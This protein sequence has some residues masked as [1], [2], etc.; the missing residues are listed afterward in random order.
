MIIGW[1][2]FGFVILI[3]IGFS[4][5]SSSRVILL[6]WTLWVAL[7]GNGLKEYCNIMTGQRYRLCWAS[8]F[9]SLISCKAEM[10]T[11]IQTL[12]KTEGA[13]KNS[14]LEPLAVL[15]IQDTGR[16][17]TKYKN[18]TQKL[19]KMSNMDPTKKRVSAKGKQFLPLLRNP[20]SYSCSQDVFYI[21]VCGQTQ[22]K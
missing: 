4:T 9:F 20:K 8:N 18:T 17:Q 6:H 12:E 5:W 21:T 19:K 10:V 7:F 13:I 11:R 16:R 15:S 2:T 3:P 22:I 14:D 1:L